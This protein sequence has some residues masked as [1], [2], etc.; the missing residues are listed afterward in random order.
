[1][2]IY[3]KNQCDELKECKGFDESL[4]V[5]EDK[6]ED[7]GFE[8]TNDDDYECNFKFENKSSDDK[9]IDKINN[10]NDINWDDI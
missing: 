7:L 4:I 8:I 6:K 9:I 3:S 1:M 5:D 10:D 2:Y